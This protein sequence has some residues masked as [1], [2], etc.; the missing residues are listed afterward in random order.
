[1]AEARYVVVNDFLP[2][3]FVRRPDQVCVQT[4]YG[5]PLKRVGLDVPHIRSTIRRSHRWHE[6]VANWQHVVSPSSFATPILRRAFAIDGEIMETGLPRSDVLARPDAAARGRDVRRRLGLPDTVRVIL[7]APTFRDHVVDRHGRHRLDLHLDLE[8]VGA[9]LGDD[10]AILFRKHPLVEELVETSG[11]VLDVST[12]PDVTELLLAADVL[13]TDYSSLMFD[14]AGTGRP[15]IYF[16]YDLDRY[17][18]E[19][20]GFYLDFRA[21][22]PGPLVRTEDE[23]VEAL[24]G[25]GDGVPAGYAERYA[26]FSEEFCKLDDGGAAGRVVERI[27]G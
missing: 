8:R 7:Y 21:K 14:F 10:T 2:D 12:Y 24:R 15:M 4:L 3:W 9:A 22:A 26:A 23:L 13:V 16:T 6:Q 19:I 27:F 11:Q 1:M 20:R 17:E 25:L 5:T 18:H